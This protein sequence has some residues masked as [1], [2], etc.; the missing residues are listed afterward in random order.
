MRKIHENPHF[1]RHFHPT[2]QESSNFSQYNFKILPSLLP[3]FILSFLPSTAETLN[4]S[5]LIP[6]TDHVNP[7]SQSRFNNW[8]L[9]AALLQRVPLSR[10]KDCR[11]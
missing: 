2:N 10:S 7:H 9:H 11:Y 3:P 6:H 8:L 4:F 5:R 1:P